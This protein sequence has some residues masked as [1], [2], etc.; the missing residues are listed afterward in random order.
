[1]KNVFFGIVRGI[2]VLLLC[3]ALGLAFIHISE[4]PFLADIDTLD[5][6][7]T[8]GYSREKILEN[9][10]AVMTYL[11]PFSGAEFSLPSLRWSA[12][13]AAHFA[14]CRSLMRGVYIAGAASGLAL[15]LLRR[16][17]NSKTLYVGALT[18]V[19]LP[20]GIALFAAV[21]FDRA[22]IAFHK[23]FFSSNNWI[24]DTRLDPIK[25]ILP[26]KYFLH[27]AL[28]IIAFCLLGVLAQILCARLIQ[29]GKKTKVKV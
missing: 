23:V 12:D 3:A 10:R 25:K 18:G 27:C 20:V 6:S 4:Q 28:I 5:I 19:L 1:M 26:D 13:G 24:F 8:S 7:A 15:L 29:R 9:Y 11:S 17:R 2:C 21:D 16:H 14:D 22:F